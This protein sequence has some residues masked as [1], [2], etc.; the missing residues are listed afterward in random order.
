M[1]T[2]PPFSLAAALQKLEQLEAEFRQP[3]LDLEVSVKKHTEAVALGKEIMQY[4][5]SVE[6]TLEKVDLAKLT[7]STE[8]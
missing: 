6:N 8:D 5:E 1:K 2:K 4:L 3:N 7:G